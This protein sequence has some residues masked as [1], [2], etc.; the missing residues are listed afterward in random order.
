MWKLQTNPRQLPATVRELHG[1]GVLR[2]SRGSWPSSCFPC[3]PTGGLA[4]SPPAQ[5]GLTPPVSRDHFLSRGEGGAKQGSGGTCKTSLGG[6]HHGTLSC[7][8]LFLKENMAASAL[9]RPSL[10]PV[11]VGP[12]S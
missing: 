2:A 1:Q 3:F 9:E 6:G 8:A 4:E 12:E 7:G 11:S 5:C 10:P